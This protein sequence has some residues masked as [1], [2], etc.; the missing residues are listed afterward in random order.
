MKN[1]E[2]AI[3]LDPRNFLLLGSAGLTYE[4]ERRFPEAA[5]Y[6]DRAVALATDDPTVAVLRARIDL[7]SHADTRPRYEAIQSVLAKDPSTVDRIADQWFDV[8]LCRRDAAEMASA[9]ASLPPEGTYGVPRSFNE[10]LAAR[11]RNDAPGAERAFTAARVAVEKV[12]HE[13]PNYAQGL[14]TLGMID[15]A[16][17]YKE[18]ALREGRRAVELLPVTKDAMGVQSC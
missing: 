6:W 4:Y 16:L 7:E 14:S 12:V 5:A 18:D 15:A 2:R 3:E 10:G 13:Q 9:L 1:Y 8:A 11:V 17:G